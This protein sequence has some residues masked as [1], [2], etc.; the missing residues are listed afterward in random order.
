MGERVGDEVGTK[1]EVLYPFNAEE[2]NLRGES[3]HRASRDHEHRGNRTAL[4]NG[5]CV[6]ALL[7]GLEHTLPSDPTSRG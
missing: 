1:N 3:P 2:R 7:R 4:S 5:R 6:P